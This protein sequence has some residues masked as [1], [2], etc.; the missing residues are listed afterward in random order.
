MSL[1]ERAFN[2]CDFECRNCGYDFDPESGIC[3]HC[4]EYNYEE[5][6]G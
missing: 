2:L 6:L 5:V 3:Q 1:K 4:G